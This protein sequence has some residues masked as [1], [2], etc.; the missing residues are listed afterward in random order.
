MKTLRKRWNGLSLRKKW[1]LATA[2]VLFI[3]FALV[4]TIVYISLHSWLLNEEKQS[5]NRSMEDLTAY[6]ENAGSGLSL[7]DLRH[8]KG[9]MNSIIDKKQTVRILNEDGVELVRINDTVA[10]VPALPETM[11][12]L[13]YVVEESKVGNTT[14]FVATGPIQLGHFQGYIQLTQPLS[15]LNALM[16]YMLTAMLLMGVVALIASWFVGA[17]LSSVLLQPIQRLSKDMTRVAAT[18]FE[19]PIQIEATTHDEVGNLIN[20]YKEMM[21]ELENA[22]VQQQRFIADASHE[23]RTPIQ[24]LEGHLSL[25]NRWGKDDR[26]ILEESLAISEAEVQKMK[27][28]IEELLALARREKKDDRDFVIVVEQVEDVVHEMTTI[29]DEAQ[30][31]VHYDESVVD[32]RAAISSNALRQILNNLIQNAVRYNSSIPIINIYLTN[33]SNNFTIV[34]EDNGI[35]M[36]QQSLEHIFERFYR[37]DKARSREHGGTGLGLSIVM[38]LVDRYDGKLTVSSEEEIGTRF[39]LHLPLYE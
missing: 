9:L 11:D 36:S 5:V 18:K 33:D 12:H 2:S 23:L 8:N 4:C 29:V 31:N 14:C 13:P 28:L 26:A 19:E 3:S 37:V 25:L 30:M 6:F 16:R 7:D 38:M 24:V 17:I 1:A 21:Q 39:T 20:V 15:S 10:E 35:G 32:V 22:F 27:Q 34:I